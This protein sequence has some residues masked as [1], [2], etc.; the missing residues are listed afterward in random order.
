MNCHRRVHHAHAERSAHVPVAAYNQCTL[1]GSFATSA[2]VDCPRAAA[3]L[4]PMQSAAHPHNAS[5][6]SLGSTASGLSS[7]PERL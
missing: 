3:V 2:W 1:R 6:S 7:S 4:D 5:E